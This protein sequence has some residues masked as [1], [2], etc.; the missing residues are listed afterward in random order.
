M[1]VVD[2]DVD[3][4]EAAHGLLDR[5]F[6]VALAADVGYLGE[7][8]APGRADLL[9]RPLAAVGLQLRD[10]DARALAREHERDAAPDPLARAGDDRD[11]AR[12]SAHSS[13]QR[14][15]AKA[16]HSLVR[17]VCSTAWR[18]RRCT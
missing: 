9:C 3:P 16:R 8:V 5:A 17:I 4:A 6:D 1:R 7:G 10:A 15:R 18:T 12:E 13:S 14:L 11:L 2:E